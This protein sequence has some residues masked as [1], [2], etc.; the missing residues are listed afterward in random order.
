VLQQNPYS[1]DALYLQANSY[2]ALKQWDDLGPVA[3]KLCTL[4]PL[5]YFER[6]MVVEASKAGKDQ[7]KMADAVMA[8]EALTVDVEIKQSQ[9]TPTGASVVGAAT[10][11]DARDASN[12]PIPGKAQTLT[13]EFLDGTGA[14]VAT[15]DVALPALA[16]DATQP[17]SVA[18]EGQGIKGWR[19]RVR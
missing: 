8:G 4:E 17:I 16:K 3:R 5:S 14:V 18:V 13:F 12:K 6:Q 11:R 2:I 15:Q 9:I 7:S 19:Y 10:G 1:R